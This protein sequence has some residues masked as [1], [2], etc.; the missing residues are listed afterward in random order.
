MLLSPLLSVRGWGMGV[1]LKK[2]KIEKKRKSVKPSLVGFIKIRLAQ[3]P[4][5]HGLLF[6]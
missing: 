1:A 5:S 3:G 4:T 6:W 2:K